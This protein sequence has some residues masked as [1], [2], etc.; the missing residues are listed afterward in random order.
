VRAEFK[1]IQPKS[2]V[3]HT[4]ETSQPSED[5]PWETAA[6]AGPELF[7][8]VHA[9][10]QVETDEFWLL[11]YLL[12]ADE[13]VEWAA[14]HL[15]LNWIENKL[16][17]EVIGKVLDLHSA[18]S[19]VGAAASLQQFESQAAQHLITRA[20]TA[21]RI[22]KAEANGRLERGLIGTILKLRN[23]FIERELKTLTQR[24][25]QPGVTDEEAMQI[26]KR[27]MELRKMKTQPIESLSLAS[28]APQRN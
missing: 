13:H 8:G 19:W 27:K 11:R 17:R 2:G 16:L 4:T 14:R 15:D 24:R 26:E 23:D 18:G 25:L 20:V 3:Q 28:E 12:A 10:L 21:R 9:N 6:I 7:A 22:E 5:D 1:K